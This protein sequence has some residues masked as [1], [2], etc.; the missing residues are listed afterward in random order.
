MISNEFT[1]SQIDLSTILKNTQNLFG[2]FNPENDG[3]FLLDKKTIATISKLIE[4]DHPFFCSINKHKIW[5][6]IENFC[7]EQFPENLVQKKELRL[8]LFLQFL[9]NFKFF[10]KNTNAFL[11]TEKQLDRNISMFDMLT[12]LFSNIDGLNKD[13]QR[14]LNNSKI[15]SEA[16]INVQLYKVFESFKSDTEENNAVNFVENTDYLNVIFFILECFS[17]TEY[18][19]SFFKRNKLN[20][21]LFKDASYSS[22]LLNLFVSLRILDDLLEG[23]LMVFESKLQ[24]NKSLDMLT[25]KYTDNKFDCFSIDSF[26]YTAQNVHDAIEFF[27]SS[28]VKFFEQQEIFRLFTVLKMDKSHEEHMKEINQEGLL[29]KKANETSLDFMERMREIPLKQ[30][31]FLSCDEY[32]NH[33]KKFQ[34]T[35]PLTSQEKTK[36]GICQMVTKP[37]NLKI[38]I[39][40]KVYDGI[41]MIVKKTGTTFNIDYIEKVT[42][43]LRQIDEFFILKA[44][45]QKEERKDN[46]DD[47]TEIGN[48][49]IKTT[50]KVI[51]RKSSFEK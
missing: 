26:K 19:L 14:I 32:L 28:M 39:K 45:Q 37:I 36:L 35:E 7:K 31:V 27:R 41:D 15:L 6:Y 44:P 42:K 46:E 29:Q 34:V 47:K 23:F 21:Y 24:A 12:S 3:K 2:L 25:A 33:L 30:G 43:D 5:N 11:S 13:K 51:S 17:K 20:Y 8:R 50:E 10:P 40:N 9:G 4:E 48:N 18:A 38:E 1:I 22:N 16:L 49:N